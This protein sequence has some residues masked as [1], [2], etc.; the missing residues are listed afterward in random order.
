MQAFAFPMQ[1][2][3]EK[4]YGA[5]TFMHSVLVTLRSHFIFSFFHC[6][7]IPFFLPFFLL[8]TFLGPGPRL[9]GVVAEGVAGEGRWG[10]L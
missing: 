9:I 2:L 8:L 1:M 6:C 10:T 5:R 4:K 3:R 7:F